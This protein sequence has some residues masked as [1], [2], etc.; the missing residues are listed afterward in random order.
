MESNTN[1]EIKTAAAV[2]R[3]RFQLIQDF[4]GKGDDFGIQAVPG[5]KLPEKHTIKMSIV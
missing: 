2:V 5:L 3:Y 1:P 4:S